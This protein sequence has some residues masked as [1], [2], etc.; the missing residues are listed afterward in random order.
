MEI[1]QDE[2]VQQVMQDTCMDI[3]DGNAA[4]QEESSAVSA[5]SSTNFLMNPSIDNIDVED[6]EDPQLVV[7]YVN[8][9]YGYMRY[10]ENEQLVREDYLKGQKSKLISH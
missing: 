5:F 8:E 6:Q 3:D 9:I 7:D 4:L 1:I 10:L 2:P